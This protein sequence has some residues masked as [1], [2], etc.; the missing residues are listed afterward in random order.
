MK[1]APFFPVIPLLLTLQS[2]ADLIRLAKEKQQL[3]FGSS[4]VGSTP[5]IGKNPRH[6]DESTRTRSP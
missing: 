1:V 5:H 3:T 4:G 2:V 6:F